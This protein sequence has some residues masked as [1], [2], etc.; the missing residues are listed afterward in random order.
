MSVVKDWPPLV[1][2]HISHYLPSIPELSGE[3]RGGNSWEVGWREACAVLGKVN[4]LH[5]LPDDFKAMRLFIVVFFFFPI[6]ISVIS[7]PR[8]ISS[9]TSRQPLQLI[10]PAQTFTTSDV[11][12]SN[13]TPAEG[14]DPCW[15][16]T[17]S[18]YL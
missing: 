8:D 2:T 16:R 15:T 5:L 17:T 14:N 4:H 9:L 11:K 1:S 12:L 3:N 6:V 13:K 10:V 18:W 7:R